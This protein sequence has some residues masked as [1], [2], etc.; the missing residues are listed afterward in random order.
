MPSVD[1]VSELDWSELDNAINNTKR[2][3]QSRFDFRGATVEIEVDR[4][5]KSLTMLSD[6]AT[7]V[8]AI[9]ETLIGEAI[10]RKIDPKALHF[11]EA[12]EALGGRSRRKA[13]VKEGLDQPT[14]KSIV[15]KIKDSKLK[16][17]ASIQGDQVRVSGKKID[18][19]QEVMRLV[20]E[21][22]DLGIPVQFVNM[23]RD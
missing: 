21:D 8:N 22:E 2:Q 18:D 14:A 10:K 16:V 5:G 7:K 20:R 11:G 19:L 3:L 6:D 9:R 13:E 23:Q 15:K 1:I 17:Q 4:K 12:E